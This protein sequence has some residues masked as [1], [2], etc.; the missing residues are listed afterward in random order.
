MGVKVILKRRAPV[1]DG[2]V[3]RPGVLIEQ[4]K[5]ALIPALPGKDIGIVQAALQ[6]RVRQMP[7]QLCLKITVMPAFFGVQDLKLIARAGIS[8]QPVRG[9]FAA[10]QMKLEQMVVSA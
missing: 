3:A 2:H 8:R 1:E 9:T 5:H 4:R 6:L 10:L 7:C